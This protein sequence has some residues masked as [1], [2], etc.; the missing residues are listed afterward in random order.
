MI[1]GVIIVVSQWLKP[2]VMFSQIEIFLLS[3]FQTL[4]QQT[5]DFAI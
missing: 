4:E 1:A 2:L 3:S 5:I